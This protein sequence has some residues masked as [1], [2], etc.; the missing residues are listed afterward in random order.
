[1]SDLPVM[2]GEREGEREIEKQ[3]EETRELAICCVR[4]SRSIRRRTLTHGNGL[5]PVDFVSAESHLN[6]S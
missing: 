1:M 3:Q 4:G 6:L 2:E 5:A